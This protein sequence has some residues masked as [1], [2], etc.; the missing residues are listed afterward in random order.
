MNSYLAK[1]DY[2]SEL[3]EHALKE[4]LPVEKMSEKVLRAMRYSLL[5]GGKRIRGMITLACY[6]L[7]SDKIEKAL[8]AAVAVEM[9]HAYSLIHD[10]L[11]CMDDDDIRRGKPSC[12]IAFGES[13]ALLAGDALL[14][15]GLAILSEIQDVNSALRCITILGDAAGFQGMVRGQELDISLCD[16]KSIK[17]NDL[18]K[19]YS[20]KTGKL[21]TA[22]AAMGS[23]I[24]KSSDEDLL[25]IEEAMK[26][27]GLVFQIVD[28]MLDT[29]GESNMSGAVD[30][31]EKITYLS[32]YD[33]AGCRSI[34]EKLTKEA[35]EILNNR[36]KS[37]AWFITQM[38]ENL[39]VRTK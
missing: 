36:F 37:K 27:I 12:H 4:S 16:K 9:V 22:A 15:K 32:I 29:P 34:A 25:T 38:A 28:D 2:Y 31:N 3:I 10:D 5:S 19:I 7:F 1:K 24:G 39:L 23:I 30:S 13:I 8:P 18:N 11:P 6:E 20:L 35:I 33:A 26:K 21:Y 14:T 17:R